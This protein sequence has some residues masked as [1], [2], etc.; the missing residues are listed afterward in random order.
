LNRE[1]CSKFAQ[2]MNKKR[3][4]LCSVKKIAVKN[5]F[6]PWP[7]AAHGYFARVAHCAADSTPPLALQPGPLRPSGLLAL[8]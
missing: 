8:R 7:L 5:Y 6:G 2:K 4:K 3:L 1:N